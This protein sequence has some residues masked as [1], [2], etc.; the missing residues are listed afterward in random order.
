MEHNSGF[1]SKIIQHL[2]FK[3]HAS[4]KDLSDDIITIDDDIITKITMTIR[5]N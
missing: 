1:F 2:R 5:H 3:L 4:E